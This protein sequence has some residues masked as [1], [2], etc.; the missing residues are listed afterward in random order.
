MNVYDGSIKSGDFEIQEI[1]NGVKI[2]YRIG[3]IEAEIPMTITLEK[4]NV[5]VSI[6]SS[7]IKEQEATD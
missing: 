3:K 4:N 1:E 2:I 5:N 7:E 6:I